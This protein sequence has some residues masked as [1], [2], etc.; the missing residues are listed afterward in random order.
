MTEQTRP[1]HLAAAFHSHTPNI[2]TVLK[3]GTRVDFIGGMYYTKDEKI[4]EELTEMVATSDQ[5]YIDAAEPYVDPEALTPY[6]QLKKK[7]KAE[8]VAEM[9]AATAHSNDRG[10]YSSDPLMADGGGRGMVTTASAAGVQLTATPAAAKQEA[11]APVAQVVSTG[12]AGLAA[13]L[14]AEKAAKEAAASAPVVEEAD[15]LAVV[16]EL[17][18]AEAGSEADAAAL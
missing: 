1:A 14:A 2:F 6:E 12:M 9:E 13:R 15:T 16:E 3:T 4:I 10:T 11:P 18:V 8:L 7:I 17:A 5:F